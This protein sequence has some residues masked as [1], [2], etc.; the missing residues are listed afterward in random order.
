M[1]MIQGQESGGRIEEDIGILRLIFVEGSKLQNRNS[2]GGMK[3][4]NYNVDGKLKKMRS[5]GNERKW[6][7]FEERKR[8]M[9]FG[10]KWRWKIVNVEKK[11]RMS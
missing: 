9:F 8:L 4:L 2:I 10:S 11:L 7:I 5:I 6:I 3:K 1:D